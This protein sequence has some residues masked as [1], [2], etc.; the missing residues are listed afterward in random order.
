[1]AWFRVLQ[2]LEGIGPAT[3]AR[4]IRHVGENRNDPRSI[5]EFPA[6]PAARRGIAS[7][8]GLLDDLTAPGTLPPASQV[9]RVRKFYDPILKDLYDNP[10]V[11]MRDL[12]N[13]EQI[14]SGY[15]S[16]RSFLVD[17]QLDPPTSTSDLAGPPSKDEDWLVLSTIHSAK[18]CEWDAVYLIHAADGCLPSDMSTGTEEEIDEERRLTYVAMTRARNFLYVVWP[19][20]YYH[21]WYAFTERHSYAQPCRFLTKDVCETLDAVTLSRSEEEEEEAAGGKGSRDIAGAIRSMW[22]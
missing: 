20:R 3:A 18:G 8:A 5:R 7:L 4:A 1:M 9:E 2:M 11:R 6:P 13:L 22:D 19:L 10:K 17:L 15:R 16:R 12:E 14:A 21:K